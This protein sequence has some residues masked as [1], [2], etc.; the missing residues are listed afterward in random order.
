[1]TSIK[2]SAE[3]L[4]ILRAISETI[5]TWHHHHHV[6]LDIAATYPPVYRLNYAEIGCYAGASSCLMLQR[7]NTRVVAIDLGIIPRTD[8][9]RNVEANN[10]H[11]NPFHYIQGDSHETSTRA[12]LAG[13]TEVVDI[14]FIDG[15]H[16]YD[17]VIQDFNDYKG[18]LPKGGYVVF[19]DYSDPEYPEVRRAVDHLFSISEGYEV[20]GTLEN[21]LGARG[22]DEG[23]TRGNCFVARRMM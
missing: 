3:S 9:M 7:R 11:G 18:F 8:V 14:L 13:I 19:D 4:N 5:P 20:I 1:M 10:P 15:T 16:K 17:D 22:F 21:L 12:H 2:P 6:L 23:D